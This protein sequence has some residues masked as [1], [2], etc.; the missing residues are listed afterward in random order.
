MDKYRRI[1]HIDMDAFFASVEQRNNPELRGKPIAVGGG[2]RGVVAAASY[3]AR[4]FGIHSAMPASQ[5]RKLCPHIIFVRGN[6]GTYK[7]VSNEVM[8]IL[9]EYTDLIEQVSIDEAYIDV[10]DYKHE[11][12][13]AKQIAI[14]IRRKIKKKLG[15]TA[16]AGI[17]FTKFLAKIASDSNKPDGYYVIHPNKADRFVR[18]LPVEKIPGVGSVSKKRLNKAGIFFGADVIERGKMKMALDFGRSGI[19]LYELLTF[20]RINPVITKR[21]RKSIGQERTFEENITDPDLLL[22]QLRLLSETLGK[23]IEQ[24]RLSGKTLTLKIKYHDFSVKTRRRTLDHHINSSEE[25]L[26]IAGDILRTPN[27]PD[28]PVRLLGIQLSNLNNR[29]KDSSQLFLEI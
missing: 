23:A 18:Q 22:E 14:E 4:K 7:K 20:T 8:A 2:H 5:A 21:L 6:Y 19:Y 17:S 28:E 24:G 25:L 26:S 12:M 13:S 27:Y 1:I 29:P 9:R 11:E 10:T 15:L 16:S 3:E